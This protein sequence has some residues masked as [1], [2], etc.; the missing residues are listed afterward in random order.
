M[1]ATKLFLVSKILFLVLFAI[2][3]GYTVVV[4]N[5]GLHAT[6]GLESINI[7]VLGGLRDGVGVGV[8][9]FV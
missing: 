5:W 8:E 9:N 3:P 7:I 4:F 1:Q 6:N 2:T